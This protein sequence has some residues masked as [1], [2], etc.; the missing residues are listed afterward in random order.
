MEKQQEKLVANDRDIMSWSLIKKAKTGQTSRKTQKKYS[1]K[2]EAS[3]KL[4]KDPW[5]QRYVEAGYVINFLRKFM[6]RVK[7]ERAQGGCLGTESRRRT[8]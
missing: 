6:T 4:D 3:K 7:L 8:R 1:E 2:S 5:K